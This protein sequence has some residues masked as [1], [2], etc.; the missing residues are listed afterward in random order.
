M[1]VVTRGM[2]EALYS[3]LS[4]MLDDWLLDEDHDE[5][6]DEANI[7]AIMRVIEAERERCAR[8]A[9]SFDFGPELAGEY[10]NI[11]RKLKVGIAAAIRKDG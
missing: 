5:D 10:G 2:A 6:H 7:Q 3:K 4:P 8:V 9:E 11:V 1:S